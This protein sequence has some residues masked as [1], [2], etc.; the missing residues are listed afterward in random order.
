MTGPGKY[1]LGATIL[2]VVAV[3]G[4][5]A[6]IGFDRYDRRQQLEQRVARLTGGDPHR[7]PGAIARY[8]CGGCHTIPGI[9]GARGLSG[10][11]LTKFGQRTF[12]A[13]QLR[14]TPANLT[15]W[16]QH[17]HRVEP[18]TA[19]PEMGVTPADARDIAAYLY[20]LN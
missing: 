12:V 10:P 20:T 11:P 14:N 9:E 13:G 4:T 5:A 15:Q 8:G 3:A 17:P 1:V 6:V 16:L 2:A 18:G 7:G 19:M